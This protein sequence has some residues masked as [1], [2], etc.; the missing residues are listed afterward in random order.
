MFRYTVQVKFPEIYSGPTVVFPKM[1]HQTLIF[2]DG[3]CEPIQIN[4]EYCHPSNVSY[5]YLQHHLNG[6]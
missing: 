4:M 3:V 1:P 5:A 2:G 6:G